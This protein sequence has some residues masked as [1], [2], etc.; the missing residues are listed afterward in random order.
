MKKDFLWGVATSAGQIEG[1]VLD[2]GRK[3]SIWDAFSRIPGNIVNN[4]TPDVACSSYKKWQDDVK[5]IKDLG[6]NS[7]RYSISWSRVLPDGKGKVN[8]A[9]LDYYKRLT[10]TLVDNGIAPN[11]T[12]YHWDL[13][14]ELHRL[15]GWLNRDIADWFGDYAEL[16]FKELDGVKNRKAHFETV[17]VLHYPNGEELYATGQVD[18]EILFEED[19]ENG[20]GYDNIF[21]CNEL[22]K[23]FGVASDQEKNSVSHR[24][25]AIWNLLEQL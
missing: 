5:L 23:S 19:G 2:D 21:F 3:F 17:V 6:V 20:F 1:G 14:Y 8:Q 4:D 15:G 24:A 12:L 11:V 16:I 7:Y 22:N 13:P 18:G 25:R 9:G 10:D